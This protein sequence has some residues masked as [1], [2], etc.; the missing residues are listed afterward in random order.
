M[1]TLLLLVLI[2]SPALA[3]T[4]VSPLV[5]ART[6]TAARAYAMVEARYKSG[7]A[8]IE[9]VYRWSVR[10]LD[11]QRDAAPKPAAQDHLKRMQTL[12]AAAK[13]RVSSGIAPADEAV[14][15]E[16]F[17]AEAALWASR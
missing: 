13:A 6:D 1:R 17:K 9:S 2:A 10:W 12:E 16:Y 5:K 14:A 4:A 8:D 11:A 7:T 3:D 15:A